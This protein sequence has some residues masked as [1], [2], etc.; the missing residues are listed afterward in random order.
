MGIYNIPVDLMDSYRDRPTILRSSDPKKLVEAANQ[1][2]EAMLVYLQLLSLSEEIDELNAT[3]MVVSLDVILDEPALDFPLLYNVKS[4]RQNIAPRITILAKPGFAKASRIAIALGLPLKIQLLHPTP[5][6]CGELAE[7]LE[8][9]LHS[10]MISEPIEFFHSLLA[11]FLAPSEMTVWDIM[12]ENPTE[13]HYLTDNG[14]LVLSQR[15]SHI[16]LD[17]IPSAFLE[18][19]RQEC[20]SE[21]DECSTCEFLDTCVGYFRLPRKDYS[22]EGVTAVLNVLKKE[23]SHLL[24]DYAISLA[25]RARRLEGDSG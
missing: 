18:D 24:K 19:V 20:L 14:D 12:E 13:W 7:V 10:T 23:V 9:Y 25:A 4:L 1:F 15:L 11:G 3:R 5:E 2:P 22:C 8:L 21:G 17:V 6:I 16:R